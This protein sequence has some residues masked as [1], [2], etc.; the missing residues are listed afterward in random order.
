MIVGGNLLICAFVMNDDTISHSSGSANSSAIGASTR[1]Q[2]DGPPHAS[3][4]SRRRW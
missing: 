1:C 3:R 4:A 2:V